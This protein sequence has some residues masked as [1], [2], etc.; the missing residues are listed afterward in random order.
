[1]PT[2]RIKPNTK[3]WLQFSD[4]KF[5][6]PVNPKELDISSS[7]PANKFMIIGKGQID[8]PQPRD[9]KKVKFSSFFPGTADDPYTYSKAQQP[10]YYTKIL[11]SALENATVG[12]LTIKRPGQSK[13]N[14]LVSIKAFDTTDTG[15]EPLDLPYDLELLEYRSFKPDK[16]KTKVK[17]T[18]KGTKTVASVEKQ[19]SNEEKNVFRVG[20][21]VLANGTYCYDSYGSKPHGTA[22]NLKVEIKRIV[23][24]RK[25]PILIGDYGWIKESSLVALNGTTYNNKNKNKE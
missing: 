23:P 16:V 14:I 6:L 2:V 13:V 5:R 24:G 9:L 11:Y 4:V 8:I 21:S 17:K 1:M 3:I 22:N 10:S 12:R 18:S 20:T 25:Y 15:G 7:S 19:R